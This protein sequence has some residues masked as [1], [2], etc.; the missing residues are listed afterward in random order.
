[1]V[2]LADP[3]PRS[4]ALKAPPTRYAGA[5]PIGAVLQHSNIPSLRMAGFVKGLHPANALDVFF[6]FA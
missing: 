5:M 1:V 3:G 2:A 6:G 4:S